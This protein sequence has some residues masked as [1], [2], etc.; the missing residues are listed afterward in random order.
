M[1]SRTRSCGWTRRPVH[2]A[3]AGARTSCSIS[4]ISI[5]APHVLA[6]RVGTVVE[7][8]NND[9]VFHNVF[10]F[11]DGKQFD[12]GLYPV[13]T[14]R[15]VT[16]DHPGLSRIFC[17]IHP[18]MGAH[19]MVVDTPYFTV[20]DDDGRFTIAGDPA[21]DLH[22][23]RV[24]T[25]TAGADRFGGGRTDGAAAGDRMALK[26]AGALVCRGDRGARER[27]VEPVGGRRGQSDRRSLDARM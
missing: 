19:V 7:F 9:R 25:G 26:L 27:R 23:P 1:P 16:F 24:A 11:H 10:S 3:H 2:A 21:R 17:N 14:M 15:R 4:G 5:S 18:N 20:S 8:P 12:L 13:G 22:V 6:V